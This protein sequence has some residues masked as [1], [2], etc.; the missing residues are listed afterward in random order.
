MW[1]NHHKS[2]LLNSAN[3]AH[4]HGRLS[5]QHLSERHFV[6]LKIK[7]LTS[8]LAR[9]SAL[10][11]LGISRRSSRVTLVGWEWETHFFSFSIPHQSTRHFK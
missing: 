7:A 8:V 2:H 9:G 11:L 1:S 10:T 6:T 5:L 4:R 3:K